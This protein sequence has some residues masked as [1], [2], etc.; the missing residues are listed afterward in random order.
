MSWDF[1]LELTYD[2]RRVEESFDEYINAMQMAKEIEQGKKYWEDLTEREKEQV[3]KI[4]MD[5]KQFQKEIIEYRHRRLA[6]YH[7]P[8]GLQA[9]Q[10][11]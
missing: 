9:A 7:T 6:A 2:E 4:I 5:R 3:R 10:E 8:D 11:S 1:D